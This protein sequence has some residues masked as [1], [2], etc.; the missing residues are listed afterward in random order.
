M[1]NFAQNVNI[2]TDAGTDER[3]DRKT[4]TIYPS[5]YFVCR[6]VGGAV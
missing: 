6:G 4:K 2:R 3:M 5:T 1:Q